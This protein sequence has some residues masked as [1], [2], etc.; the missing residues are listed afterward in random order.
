VKILYGAALADLFHYLPISKADPTNVEVRQKLLLASWMSLWP[1]KFEQHAA[2]SVIF[3]LYSRLCMFNAH[4][5]HPNSPFGL[6]H[7]LGNRLGVTMASRTGS[8]P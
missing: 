8:P 5:I 1:T 4:L 2:G 6:S 7:A 3:N